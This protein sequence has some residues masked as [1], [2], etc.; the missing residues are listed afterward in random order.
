MTEKIP[1]RLHCLDADKW[2]ELE[3]RVIGGTGNIYT[4]RDYAP[5]KDGKEQYQV[6]VFVKKVEQ[7]QE[8]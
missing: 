4:S 5:S 2:Q 7:N 8:D 6:R 1:N 3:S